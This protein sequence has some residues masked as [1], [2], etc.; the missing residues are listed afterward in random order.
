MMESKRLSGEILPQ[1]I[2]DAQAG[3]AEMLA[4][5]IY[6]DLVQPYMDLSEEVLAATGHE[7][8]ATMPAQDDPR[9]IVRLQRAYAWT[10]R[11]DVPHET[12]VLLGETLLS[13]IRD[14]ILR[15]EV[16]ASDEYGAY[17]T[18]FALVLEKLHA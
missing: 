17:R 1:D 14:P 2:V 11:V 6:G 4:R 8:I 5:C 7:L 18:K 13:R 10:V 15:H 12:G 16:T 9:F 3:R